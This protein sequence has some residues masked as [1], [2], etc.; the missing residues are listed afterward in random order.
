MR[1]KLQKPIPIS[2]VLEGSF[3]RLGIKRRVN[4]FAILKDW[5]RLAGSSISKF[6]VPVKLVGKTLY[7]AVSTSVWMEELK[8]VKPDLINK[9]NEN[10]GKDCVSDIIFKLGSINCFYHD[11]KQ[12]PVKER[13]LTAEEKME[14]DNVTSGIKDN[15]LREIISGI[16]R[17]HKTIIRS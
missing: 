16:I 15:G 9:I 7:V 2:A 17:K 11:V 14:I 6:A 3:A 12:N 8:Y 5:G 10:L 4:E 13:C 1:P